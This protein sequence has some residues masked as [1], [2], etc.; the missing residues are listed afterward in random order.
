MPIELATLAPSGTPLATVVKGVLAGSGQTIAEAET[1]PREAYTSQAFFDLEME[2]IFRKDW[3]CVGHI[4]QIPDVGDYF[5][6]DV[7]NELLVVVRGADRVRVMSRVCLHRW[8]PVAEGQGN[9]KL[10]SCPFHRWAY[11]LDGQLVATPLMESAKGFD[12]AA[13]R[14]P[15]VRSEI[16]D[17]VI[18][19]T[20]DKD[21]YSIG[22][23]LWDLRE[24]FKPYGMEALVVGW[25]IDYVCN[26]NWKIAVETFM[27]CYHHIGGHR[28]S[29][30]PLYPARLTYVDDSREGWTVCWE[31]LRPEAA[32]EEALGNGMPPFPHLT[33]AEIRKDCLILAYPLTLFAVTPARI[34]V[35]GLIPVSPT[36]TLWR[37]NMLVPRSTAEH[38]DFQK[39]VAAANVFAERIVAE[40]LAVN[41]MQQIGANSQFALPGRLSDL[42]KVVWQLAD[43]VRGRV[44]A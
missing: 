10:F 44:R 6:V 33:E 15:E 13:C 11:G 35:I 3:L 31:E 1:L 34:G 36:K 7:L 16:V 37:R 39:Q 26:F 5:T 4:A 14:L 23:K 43:F 18:Y 28:E 24:F 29:V 40:D 25:Q 32:T 42:E 21:A 22:E 38:P 9:T 12:P 20:F 17:G 27:E 8:A 30:E 2:K 41:D 19:I